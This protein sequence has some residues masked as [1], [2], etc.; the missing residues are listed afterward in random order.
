MPRALLLLSPEEVMKLSA[1]M[2]GLDEK[3]GR[4]DRLETGPCIR[5]M[6]VRWSRIVQP[7]AH[8]GDAKFIGCREC[9]GVVLNMQEKQN[10]IGST[11]CIRGWNC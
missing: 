6:R 7:W 5:E 4:F 3:C 9:V 8:W 1:L 10:V 2:W 11:E